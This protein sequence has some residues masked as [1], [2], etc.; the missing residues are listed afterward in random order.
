VFDS[1]SCPVLLAI[2]PNQTANQ[3]KTNQ[4]TNQPKNEKG[5][6][7]RIQILFFIK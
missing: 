5:V 6:D 3:N 1:W 2:K 4:P 7:Y